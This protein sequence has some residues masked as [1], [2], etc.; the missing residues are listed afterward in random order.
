MKIPINIGAV[1]K[2]SKL[3]LGKVEFYNGE[4]V[5]YYLNGNYERS[6]V[7]NFKILVC[8]QGKI[9]RKTIEEVN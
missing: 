9:I 6:E 7:K 3:L 4:T 8:K 2:D 5:C 1:E